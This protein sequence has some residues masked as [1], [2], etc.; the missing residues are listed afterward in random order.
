MD[1][2]MYRWMGD[3]W[4]MER[5]KYGWMSDGWMDRKQPKRP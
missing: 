2:W 4:M 5:S 3:E 1:Q